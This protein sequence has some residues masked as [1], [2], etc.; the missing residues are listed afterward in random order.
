[1][2]FI[3]ISTLENFNSAKFSAVSSNDSY[4]TGATPG[5]IT[6]GTP[7]VLYEDLAF[8]KVAKMIYTHGALYQASEADLSGYYTKGQIDATF[9]TKNELATKQ[10]QISGNVGEVVYHDG[11]DVFTQTI[12][13][14]GYVV[15][16]TEDLNKCKNDTTSVGSILNT[17]KRFSVL[18]GVSNARPVEIEAWT[19]SNN[20]LT[21]PLDTESFVGVIS[22][23]AYSNYEVIVKCF[24]IGSDSATIG[25]VAAYAK[26][27]SGKEHTLSFLRTPGGSSTTAKPKW[28]AVLD[29][30]GSFESVAYNQVMVIDNS[31]TTT[32]PASVADWNST[33]LADGTTIK[34]KRTGNVFTATC[35]QFGST[36]VDNST[37]ITL[38]LDVYST[39]YPL[40]KLFTGSAPW[41][42]AC[43][44]QPGTKFTNILVTD[45]N[46]YIYDLT[47]NTVLEFNQQSEAWGVVAEKTPMSEVGVGRFSYNRTT[48]KLF[49]NNGVEILEVSKSFDSES[50]IVTDVK[51]NGTSVVTDGKAEITIPAQ[52][53]S[54]WNEENSSS[55]AYIQNKPNIPSAQVQADWTELDS[56][57]KAYIQHKPTIPTEQVQAN[58][59]ESD[60][61]SKA[62]IQNKPTIPAEQV[63]ADWNEANISS[64]AYIQNK[65]AIPAEQV[66]ANWTE[67]NSASKAYIQNKPTIPAAQV[68]ADW[69]EANSASKAYIQN[70]PTIPEQ[71]QSDWDESDNT[72]KAYI[73][74]KPSIPEQVQA[75]WNESDNTSKA[76]I[77]NKPSIPP[78]QVQANWNESD[79]TSKAYI[80]NK[81]TIPEQV[82]SDWTELDTTSKAYIQHKPTIPAAQ[83]QSNW[84]ELD[85]TSK[86]YILNKPTIPAAQVQSDWEESNTSSKAFIRNK[87]S[88]PAAQIQSDWSESDTTSKAYIQNKPSIPPAT[89]VTQV[90]STG[91]EIARVNGTSIYS[92]TVTFPLHFVSASSIY[93]DMSNINTKDYNVNDLVIV[94]DLSGTLSYS[95]VYQGNTISSTISG[96]YGA[97]VIFRYTGNGFKPIACP[98]ILY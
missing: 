71:V 27:S 67:E 39:S 42:Y 18:D 64:K 76:F 97:D 38:D 96:N 54:D 3:H 8:C 36:S 28:A 84:E 32:V 95:F 45:P 75:N 10:N 92:P 7:T 90:V 14:D 40:L 26:D 94:M 58:W 62:Y 74:N 23:K 47:S 50:G 69:N 60:T 65:P 29:F 46:Y 53:Q 59:N 91:T 2:K 9:A 24:S 43:F 70:K 77:Q 48:N 86:A 44:S 82:Q 16:T 63:Q 25:I 81:P 87:P 72:S 52:V 31:A 78:V 88:I 15:N 41:G 33:T 51:V 56:T 34:V 13:C 1:M 6:E 73:L 85:S 20:T 79:T 4:F 37:V 30:N 55:K 61:A 57:S 93:H 11:S 89:T 35:S 80:Q 12:M 22:P 21:Q 98:P 66:Q 19:S 83:V 17:W 49:Y 68:Q 5:I